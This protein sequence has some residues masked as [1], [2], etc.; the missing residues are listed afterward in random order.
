MSGATTPVPS[1]RRSAPCSPS[2]PTWC[3][4][5]QVADDDYA[6]LSGLLSEQEIVEVAFVTAQ[7]LGLAR[8]M[9]ALRIDPEDPIGPE[10]LAATGEAIAAS[11]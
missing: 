5:G 4:D 9:T 6:A 3:E 8:M 1:T 2:S 11:P 10:G 7:Y